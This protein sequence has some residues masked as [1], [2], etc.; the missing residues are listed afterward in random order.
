MWGGNDPLRGNSFEKVTCSVVRRQLKNYDEEEL[1][2][3]PLHDGRTR[4]SED[5]A[6]LRGR[7]P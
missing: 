1:I 4:A 3:T 7:K 6:E 5:T 2:T